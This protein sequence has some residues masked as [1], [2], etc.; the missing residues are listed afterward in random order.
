MFGFYLLEYAVWYVRVSV[1]MLLFISVHL[2]MEP[3]QKRISLDTKIGRENVSIW[4]KHCFC[5]FVCF[6]PNMYPWHL[7]KRY[8]DIALYCGWDRYSLSDL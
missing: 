1:Q 2:T 4:T 3:K 8:S 6:H 5:L 7:T